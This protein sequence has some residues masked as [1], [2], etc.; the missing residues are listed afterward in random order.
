MFLLVVSA[1]ADLPE[2]HG[3]HGHERD[4]PLHAHAAEEGGGR[5]DGAHAE[6]RRLAL[7]VDQTQQPVPYPLPSASAPGSVHC[8][9]RRL[10]GPWP[11]LERH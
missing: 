8:A 1:G 10:L 5:R 6:P 11:R 2:L 4:R 9:E 7:P 3:Q